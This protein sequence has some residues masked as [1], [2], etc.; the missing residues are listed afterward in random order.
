[1]T[2]HCDVLSTHVNNRSVKII[3][4]NYMLSV[5]GALLDFDVYG[6]MTVQFM[7]EYN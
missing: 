1:M 4:A 6:L 3:T 7:D 2:I 5:V